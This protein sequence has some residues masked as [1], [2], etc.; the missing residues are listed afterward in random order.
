M[1]SCRVWATFNLISQDPLSLSAS[2]TR[3]AIF[4]DIYFIDFKQKFTTGSFARHLS[5]KMINNKSTNST[6]RKF[7]NSFI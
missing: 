7:L 1:P 4:T 5:N 3:Q 6:Y 2:G